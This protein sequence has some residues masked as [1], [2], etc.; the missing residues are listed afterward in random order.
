MPPSQEDLLAHL[1]DCLR[2]V[3]H[4][5]GMEPIASDDPHLRFADAVD[6]MGMVEFLA[7]AADASG[8][9]PLVIEECVNHQFS[10][11]GALAKAMHSAGL[12]P[13]KQASVPVPSSSPPP[14]Q[15][16]CWLT[17]VTICLPDT[18]Q[19]ASAINEVL[20]RPSGWLE[21]HA[22][23]KSRR[24]W[25]H[26][27]PMEAAVE[28][29]RTCLDQAKVPAHQ[30]GAL[31]V[32]SE[33]PP[34]LAGLAAALHHRLNL[35]SGAVALEIGGACT[36]FLAAL[37]TAQQLVPRT[38]SVLIIA[39]EA[40]TQYLGLQP[41]LAGEA[42]ALFGDGT[43]AVLLCDRPLGTS[44]VALEEVILG[45]D[46]SA[47]HFLQVERTK[48]GSVE[49]HMD[50]PPLAARAVRTMAQA[51]HNLA[52]RHGL[53]VGDLAAVVVHGGN[54]R[55]PA[56]LA[57]QLDLPLDRIWSETPHTGNLGSATLPVAW[58][59]RPALGGPVVWTAVGAGL[60]WGAAIMISRGA[61]SV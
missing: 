1:L 32:T 41:G 2:Q 47:R 25:S 58:A 33:A 12:H 17:S 59:S 9:T 38:H 54:G 3:Q 10:T 4:N 55:M 35:G 51:V 61:E 45:V 20:Q 49:L 36:G 16:T 29:G 22:G 40:H 21:S 27:E 31:L 26:Q 5:L 30:V 53:A 42:A 39:L 34:M 23:I 19:P 56:L 37:W 7:L 50:G 60:T 57:R 46:G 48:A 14:P 44:S 15:S 11:I 6:S 28:A 13:S 24:I 8:T 43:A 18:V 52:E